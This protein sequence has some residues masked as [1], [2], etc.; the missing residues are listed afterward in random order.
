VRGAAAVQVG[1][2]GHHRSQPSARRSGALLI[3]IAFF[4]IA[5]NRSSTRHFSAVVNQTTVIGTLALA[6]HSSSSLP[7]SISPTPRSQCS[8]PPDNSGGQ[9]RLPS[10]SAGASII[11]CGVI[12]MVSDCCHAIALAAIH[13]ALGMLAV[14][15]AV[16]NLYSGGTTH[17]SPRDYSPGWERRPT[18]SAAYQ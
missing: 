10:R 4:S 9:R 3:E 13:R 15:T 8:A 18:S 5:T 11:A 17:P 1:D 12:A 7:E 16:T 6:R 2:R 14:M